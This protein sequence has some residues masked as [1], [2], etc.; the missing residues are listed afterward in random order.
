MR[1]ILILCLVLL[2]AAG[3]TG[4]AHADAIAPGPLDLLLHGPIW[5]P[6]LL[7]AVVVIVTV[8]LLR[9][10]RKKK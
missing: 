9:K 4:V 8:L 2:T 7:V 10:F 3:L 6:V 1:R 5:L